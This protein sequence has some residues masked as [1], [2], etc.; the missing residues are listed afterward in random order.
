MARHNVIFAV[1]GSAALALTP[2]AYANA[3]S[4]DA[5][6]NA[7]RTC[8]DY[9]V[10]P[11]AAGF[12]TCVDRA[13]LAYDRGEP[14]MADRQAATVRDAHDVCRSYGLGVQTLGFKQCVSNE[15][16]RSVA[17]ADHISYLT[18]EQPHQGVVVDAYGFQYDRDGNLLDPHG[19]VI[20]YVPR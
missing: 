1:L 11:S 12:D 14:E 4:G 13:A 9:G 7:E 19:Y 8:M 18:A 2:V 15:L 3:Q 20:R 5:L 17:E 6:A 10:S 16:H